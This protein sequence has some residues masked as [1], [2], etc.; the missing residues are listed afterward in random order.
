MRDRAVLIAT[1]AGL[2]L[3]LSVFSD[4]AGAITRIVVEADAAQLGVG[5][6]VQNLT[7]TLV[8]EAENHAALHLQARQ[9]E[10]ARPRSLIR[11]IDI[12]CGVVE[13]REPQ[14]A[15][16]DG[17]IAAVSTPLGSFRGRLDAAFQSDRQQLDLNVQ[18]VA[19]AGGRWQ[20]R[21]AWLPAG[22]RVSGSAT[23]TSLSALTG[24]MKPWWVMPGDLSV[25]GAATLNIEAQG[26]DTQLSSATIRT[27]LNELDV[28]NGDGSVATEH[29]R[30]T[31][32][33]TVTGKPDDL[34]AMLQLHGLAG[35]ALAGPV[36]LDLTA[37]PL[38][39]SAASH[40]GAANISITQLDVTQ[41]GLLRATGRIELARQPVISIAN[42]AFNVTILQFPAAYTSL[43]QL[44]LAD[45]NFGALD[46][47]GTVGGLIELRANRLTSIDLQLNGLEFADADRKLKLAGLSGELHWRAA[48]ELAPAASMLK[49]QQLHAFGLE[50]GESAL[51][52]H[53]QGATLKLERPARIA[54][55]D[56]ALAVQ[57]FD[58]DGLGSSNVTLGFDADIEPVSMQK[59]SVAFGWPE[60]SGKLSGRLPGLEFRDGT[61][62]VA[63]DIVADVF[64]GRVTAS[65]LQ[66]R[67]VLGTFPR[68]SGDFRARGLNLELIT[69]TFPIGSITGRLDA[70]ILALE[71]FNWAPIAFDAHLYTTAGDRTRHRISQKAVGS[72]A[73][74][75]G[76][77]GG[78]T[79]ALQSGLL[80]FFNDFGYDRIGLRCQLR[81]DVCLMDGIERSAG[82]FYIVK[83]GG[84]PRIDVIGNA[85][86]VAWA[87][88]VSQINAALTAQDVVVR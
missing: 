39:V 58:A 54:I 80:R 88:L 23:G 82:S 87:Q 30:A 9:L 41:P 76:G 33:L 77:G 43:L 78:V 49:W 32:D 12:E 5:V 31:L 8:L 22:W 4:S 38:S 15:C 50:S 64:D 83:G 46:T 44:A 69:R 68:L 13:L 21:A 84:L 40:I 35:Q 19:L 71:L 79:A 11:G 10:F 57:R 14:F 81:N 29:L 51:Q 75:G 28:H 56:G 48:G 27:E 42:G 59:L 74:I 26:R 52:L 65:K 16:R 17:N 24:L 66:M 86:R 25:A 34:N 6:S 20:M 7:A 18:D 55:F 53:A 1:V 67:N 85:G 3:L 62:S 61:L 37:N 2:T 45:S 47:S 63:G 72:L 73:N 36:L 60:M 70:D